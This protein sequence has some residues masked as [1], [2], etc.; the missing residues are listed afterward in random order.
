MRSYQ[1]LIVWQ[2]SIELVI[3]LY[4]LTDEFPT[5]ERYGLVSQIRRSAVS[6]PSNI[7]EGYTRKHRLEYLQFIRVAFGSGAELET[8]LIIAKKLNLVS[9]QTLTKTEILLHDIMKMLNGLI[10][11]LTETT[12]WQMAK[13]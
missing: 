13:P 11:S 4:K 12:W 10:K 2:K 3:E 5:S 1:E 9:P 7:A 8:Q 6:I